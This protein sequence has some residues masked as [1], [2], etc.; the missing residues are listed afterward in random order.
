MGIVASSFLF[1]HHLSTQSLFFLLP[2]RWSSTLMWLKS[3]HRVPLGPFTI[4]MH[5]F[6][7]MSTFS[8]TPTVWLLAAV[9]VAKLL[10]LFLTWQLSLESYH[11]SPL[12]KILQWLPISLTLKVKLPTNGLI[13]PVTS[14]LIS[15]YLIPIQLIQK[16]SYFKV[17]VLVVS[18]AWNVLSSDI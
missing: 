17:F 11:I 9:D 8:G 7:V 12:L 1:P 16:H 4:T 6:T 15:L 18:S 5:P 2:R 10:S 14:D 13:P 3:L